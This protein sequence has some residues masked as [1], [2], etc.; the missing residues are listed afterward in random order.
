MYKTYPVSLPFGRA[1]GSHD[2]IIVFIELITALISAGTDG[3]TKKKKKITFSPTS[4][5]IDVF[6][7]FFGFAVN[8]ITLNTVS[9]ARK[10]QHRYAVVRILR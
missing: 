6:T 5:G 1:G 8:R 7:V 4:D 9:F 10:R 3:A 2:T